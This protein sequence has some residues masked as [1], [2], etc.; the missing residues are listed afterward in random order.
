MGRPRLY[1]TSV[2]RKAA[3]RRRH[4]MAARPSYPS[5]AAKQGAY[6]ARKR[7]AV[8]DLAA[9]ECAA[10]QQA[11]Q[12][13][14]LADQCWELP[15]LIDAWSRDPDMPR[16]VSAGRPP[17]SWQV[18]APT[19]TGWPRRVCAGSAGAPAPGA[20]PGHQESPGVRAARHGVTVRQRA[21]GAAAH[22]GWAALTDYGTV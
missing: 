4:G 5:A 21:R 16:R 19:C 8:K 12:T 14:A 17:G 3:W 18:R 15:E 22:G 20:G 7:Q 10:I 13:R 2:E 11:L 1:A 9:R 6:R